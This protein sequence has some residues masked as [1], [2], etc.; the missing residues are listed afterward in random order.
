MTSPLAAATTNAAPILAQGAAKLHVKPLPVR[1]RKAT[2]PAKAG[3]AVVARARAQIPPMMELATGCLFMAF[4]SVR[5]AASCG[6]TR[7]ATTHG[8]KQ[9]FAGLGGE[10]TKDAGSLH[11]VGMLPVKAPLLPLEWS[12]LPPSVR[13]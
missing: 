6:C 2:L 5:R 10:R 8:A 13:T 7:E 3:V 9:L 1:E 11:C 12:W 4:A